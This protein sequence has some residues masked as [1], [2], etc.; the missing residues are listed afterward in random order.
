M[1]DDTGAYVRPFQ[2]PDGVEL[3]LQEFLLHSGVTA[4]GV[5][6]LV[7]GWSGYTGM[8]QPLVDH[9]LKNGGTSHA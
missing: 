7:H 6:V 2:R 1:Q 3:Y 4:R 5:A 8:L 9:L